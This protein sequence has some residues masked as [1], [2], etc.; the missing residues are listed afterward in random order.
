[1]ASYL[2]MGHSYCLQNS[3]LELHIWLKSYTTI[4]IMVVGKD[5]NPTYSN[6]ARY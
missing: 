6:F 2:P 3:H 1:M 5:C 4:Q